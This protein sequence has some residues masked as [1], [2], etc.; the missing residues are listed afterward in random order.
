MPDRHKSRAGVWDDMGL[1]FGALKANARTQLVNSSPLRRTL[2]AEC[3]CAEPKLFKYFALKDLNAR[4]L[5]NMQNELTFSMKKSKFNSVSIWF[6]VRFAYS[7][8]S[9]FSGSGDGVIVLGTGPKDPQTHWEQAVVVLPEDIQ[10]DDSSADLM[11]TSHSKIRI[12]CILAKSA[13]NQRHYVVD[14]NMKYA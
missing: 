1:K 4:R 7:E 8:E 6:D 2:S 9:K 13:E 3:L 5:E 11:P 10:V 12:K 14:L